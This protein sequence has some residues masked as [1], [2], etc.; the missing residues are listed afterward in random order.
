MLAP[1]RADEEDVHGSPVANA[2]G[3]VKRP[4]VDEG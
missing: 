4:S 1:T 3:Q 2:A